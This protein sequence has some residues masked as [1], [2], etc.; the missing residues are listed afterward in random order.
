MDGGAVDGVTVDG[1]A[2]DDVGVD[3]VTVGVATVDGVSAAGDEDDPHPETTRPRQPRLTIID[4][5]VGL[6]CLVRI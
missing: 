3:V 4:L 5:A 1:G 6:S 2:V